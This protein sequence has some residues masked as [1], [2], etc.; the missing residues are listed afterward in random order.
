MFIAF[1]LEF[2]RCVNLVVIQSMRAA[3]DVVFPTLLGIG[4]MWGISVVFAWILGIWFKLGLPGVWIA[5]A[6]DDFFRAIVVACRWKIGLWR[7]RSVVN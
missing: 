7:G 1:I 6:S 2:G 4:S 3:G 5:M